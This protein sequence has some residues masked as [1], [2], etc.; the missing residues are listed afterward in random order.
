MKI[1]K[2]EVFV[3]G[4]PPAE[5]PD[6]GR[7]DGLAFVRIHTDEGLTGLSEIFTVP[8]DV[9]RA[10]LDGPESLFGRLLLGQDPCP[11]ERLWTKLYNSMLHGNRRGWVIICLG[12]VD[13]AL[14]DLYGKALQQPVYQ[15]LGGAERNRHQIHSP[16]Q[17]HQVVPYCTIVSDQWDRDSVLEQQVDR[18]VALRREGYRAFKVEPMSQTDETIVE[19]T[20]LTREAVGPDILLCVDV[21]YL[22]NDVAQALR[23]I[24]RLAEYDI[25]FFE[26]P[27]PV[28]S[29]DAYAQLTARTGIPIA[30]G[31]HTVTRWEF[32]Q[33]MDQGG[34]Q[35]AQPYMTTC[36]G[37]TEAKRIVDLALPRGVRVCPGNWSTHVL[38]A[39]T[40]HLTA[41]SP[42][43]PIFECAPAQSYYSP[44]RQALQELFFP[45]VDG[46]IDLPTAP[47][48]GL[49]LPAEMV[50]HFLRDDN[51]GWLYHEDQTD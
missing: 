35:V 12:A 15:L 33:L 23:V 44:L 1:T 3:L 48:I 42:I 2:T 34:I 50:R 38:G 27:F 51:R 41:Y 17:R 20:R 45:L 19:L 31:E 25:Y 8:P 18:V 21:G 32:L 26:T 24:E 30:V 4:D 10:V 11:P 14:W 7:I 28:D 6:T 46:A 9:A 16:Q 43:S 40:V 37:I 5:G 36:G 13:V 47:G 49:E 39:A 22:W 29:I